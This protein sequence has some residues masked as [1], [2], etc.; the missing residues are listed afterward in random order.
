MQKFN[1]GSFSDVA[2]TE[3]GEALWKF[4][5]SKESLAC[6]E[7]TTFLHRPALEGIQPQLN[8]Y[9]GKDALTDRFKQMIGRMVKQIMESRGYQLEKAN[10]RIRVGDIFSTAAR[11]K[12]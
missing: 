9:F 3:L 4:L 10:V 2:S 7:T 12:K 8:T 1:P 6:L 5:N 11:Y